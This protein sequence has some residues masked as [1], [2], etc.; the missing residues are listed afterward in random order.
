VPVVAPALASCDANNAPHTLTVSSSF[1]WVHGIGSSND[2]RSN[3]LV[4]AA[5][6][7]GCFVVVYGALLASKPDAF[8]KFHDTF[9][10]R[11]KWNRNAE[12]RKNVYNADYKSFGLVLVVGGIFIVFMM[13]M[14]LVSSQH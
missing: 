5:M 6:L 4:L 10:D 11:S 12:W 13:V 9:V 2:M 3:I 1:G 8:L 14:K 7:M